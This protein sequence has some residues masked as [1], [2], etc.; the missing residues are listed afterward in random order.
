MFVESKPQKLLKAG[1]TRWL[2]LEM[3]IN[4]LLEQYDTLCSFFRSSEERLASIQRITSTLENPLTKLYLMFLS[5]ALQVINAFNK[6]KQGEAPTIHF[7]LREVQGF[8]KKLLLRFKVPT[9]I[10]E[11]SLSQIEL[12]DSVFTCQ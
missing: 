1:Q 8:I 10:Q 6:L 3:C 9:V 12:D 7:L 2:S 11:Q 4:C 5:N